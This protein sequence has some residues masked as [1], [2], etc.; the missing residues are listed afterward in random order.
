MHARVIF[1]D[2]N[3]PHHSRFSRHCMFHHRTLI[4]LNGVARVGTT[5]LVRGHA[6][7][8]GAADSATRGC[9][10]QQRGNY[11]PTIH[12]QS[13]AFKR[14]AIALIRSSQLFRWETS[15]ISISIFTWEMFFK[16]NSHENILGGCFFEKIYLLKTCLFLLIKKKL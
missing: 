16:L 12:R 1:I 7:I 6:D 15:W 8:C 11:T 2:A 4:L 13:R 14:R 3:T 10:P 5:W 9:T